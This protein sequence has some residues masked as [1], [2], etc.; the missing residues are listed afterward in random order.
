[1]SSPPKKGEVDGKSVVKQRIDKLLGRGEKKTLDKPTK[2]VYNIRKDAREVQDLWKDYITHNGRI[3]LGKSLGN[4]DNYI[5]YFH[6]VLIQ[7][8]NSVKELCTTNNIPLPIMAGGSLR[9][10]FYNNNPKDYDFF[11]NTTSEEEAYELIDQLTIAMM[12]HGGY[13]EAGAAE[14]YGREEADFEGVYAVFNWGAACQFV[15]GVWPDCEHIY[16]RFDL[17]VCQAEMDLNTYDI[18]VSDAFLDSVYT[19]TSTLFKPDSVYS[20]TRKA[21]ID[22]KL[23]FHRKPIVKTKTKQTSNPCSEIMLDTTGFTV[24]GVRYT[25]GKYAWFTVPYQRVQEQ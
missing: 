1:M 20:T 22:E 4:G 17:S 10:L 11:F 13:Q 12:K 9:D 7:R 8:A 15:V 2:T 21:I 18:V 23:Q 25:H 19:R 5:D 16:D 24:E 3:E 14:G 6:T